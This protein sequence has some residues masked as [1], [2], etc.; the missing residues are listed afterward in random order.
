[1]SGVLRNLALLLCVGYALS[2]VL[3]PKPR[4]ILPGGRCVPGRCCPGAKCVDVP[5]S[6][7][8]ICQS[9][10]CLPTGASCTLDGKPCC[11]NLAC[12]TVITGAFPTDDILKRVCFNK[13]CGRGDCTKIPCCPG[14]FCGNF[15]GVSSCIY[16]A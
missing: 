13:Y 14:S 3:S 6:R 10:T 7:T 12:K 9:N 16:P 15:R 2:S 8:G 11:P 5:G 4:C 1:M